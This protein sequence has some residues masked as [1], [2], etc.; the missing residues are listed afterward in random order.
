MI[1]EKPITGF[2]SGNFYNFYKS[3]ADENFVTY[4]SKNP[5]QS[6]IHNYF[7]MIAVEQ[8]V[9][10]LVIFVLLL[11]VT[12]LKAEWLF[13]KLKPGYPR[14]LL[15]ACVASLFFIL[16]ILLLND[17]IETDKIGSFFFFCL[18]MIVALEHRHLPSLSG[19][20]DIVGIEGRS[21]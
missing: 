6:G 14:K 3:Y 12:L 8:G 18:A 21:E 20:H 15:S 16:F 2:G 13:H 7:L 5:E 11:V 4:V 19:E 17:M 10:G 1:K 9:P